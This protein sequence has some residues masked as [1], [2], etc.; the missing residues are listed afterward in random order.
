MN[1]IPQ[2]QAG[3]SLLLEELEQVEATLHACEKLPN[4]LQ[5]RHKL[6][7]EK[8]D[9]LTAPQIAHPL[10]S[11]KIIIR[12]YEYRGVYFPCGSSID[13]YSSLLKSFW[14]DFPG[15]REALATAISACGTLRKYVARSPN[16]LF[17][18]KLNDWVDRHCQAF[19]DGWYLDTNLN[20]AQKHRILMAATKFLKLR[21]GHD[22]KVNWRSY[23]SR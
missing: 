4:A 18:G 16:D 11:P 22:V 14:N 8:L 5:K 23:F 10:I 12:G 2:Q 15:Q 13:I 17:T 1:A 3:P 9:R 21:W 20:D 7:V 19:T 6:L